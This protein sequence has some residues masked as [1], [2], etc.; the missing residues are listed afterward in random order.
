MGSKAKPKSK[1]GKD[2]AWAL[3]LLQGIEAERNRAQRDVRASASY[4]NGDDWGSISGINDAGGWVEGELVRYVL[5]HAKP[6][7]A[8]GKKGKGK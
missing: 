4:W 3:K 8:R 1:V 5:K 7:P 6:S 2:V